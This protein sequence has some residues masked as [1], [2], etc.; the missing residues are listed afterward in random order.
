MAVKDRTKPIQ[1]VT[2]KSPAKYLGPQTLLGLTR[3]L[4]QVSCDGVLITAWLTDEDFEKGFENVPEPEPKPLVDPTKPIRLQREAWTDHAI[5]MAEKVKCVHCIPG[6]R[7][8]VRIEWMD[9]RIREEWWTEDIFQESFENVPE[10]SPVASV[11]VDGEKLSGVKSVDIECDNGAAPEP[12]P[13][14]EAAMDGRPVEHHVGLNYRDE[15]GK[16]ERLVVYQVWMRYPKTAKT[17]D[18]PVVIYTHTSRREAMRFLIH[19][20]SLPVRQGY[21]FTIAPCAAPV[22][23]K[24]TE[25]DA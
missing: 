2:T 4:V 20:Q 19:Q 7:Y 13:K 17:P 9:G 25:A 11:T 14:W 10:E 16:D 8:F 23:P 3:H 5:L 1:A 12:D 21:L 24:A 15:L 6:Y 18:W 22:M